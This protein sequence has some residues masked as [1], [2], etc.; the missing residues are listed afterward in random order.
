MSE[1]RVT[2]RNSFGLDS[3]H[4]GLKRMLTHYPP[5]HPLA[6]LDSTYEGLKRGAWGPDPRAG[7]GLDST[8]EGLKPFFGPTLAEERRRFG[9]YL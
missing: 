8:Y 6:C 4:E 9:Q 1:E 7:A 3:T 2:D 5:I